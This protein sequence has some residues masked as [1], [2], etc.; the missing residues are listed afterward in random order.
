M[1]SKIMVLITLIA[2][3]FAICDVIVSGFTCDH[4]CRHNDWGT[5]VPEARK[6]GFESDNKR[7]SRSYPWGGRCFCY[8]PPYCVD[9]PAETCRHNCWHSDWS[10]RDRRARAAGKYGSRCSYGYS[11]GT[12][13]GGRCYC[14]GSPVCTSTQTDQQLLEFN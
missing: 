3:I 10:K 8:G 5:R 7:C 14:Y 2:L 13:I 9:V 6:H 1:V 4:N 12:A 11:F